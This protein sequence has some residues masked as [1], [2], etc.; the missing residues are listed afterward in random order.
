[1]TTN[2]KGAIAETAIAFAATKL[3]LDVY[4]PAAEGGRYDLIFVVD[5]RL[6]QV[7]LAARLGRY[8]AVAQLGER[9]DGIAEV[10]GSI[11]LGS[12]FADHGRSEA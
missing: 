5:D 7:Q 10:R 1:M 11:P 12:T 9:R 6:L 2:R 4:R 8:G 3:G